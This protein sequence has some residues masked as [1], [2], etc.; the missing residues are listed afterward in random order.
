MTAPAPVPSPVAARRRPACAAWS[1]HAA[2]LA[3]PVAAGIERLEESPSTQVLVRDGVVVRLLPGLYLPPDLLG[4][5][6]GRALALGAATGDL[7][8]EDHV[9]A[10]ASAA[11]VLLGGAP[12][13]PAEMLSRAHRGPVAGVLVRSGRI[14]PEEVE[15]LGGAPVTTPLRTAVDLLVIDPSP[16]RTRLVGRLLHEG[17]LDGEEVTGRLAGMRSHPGARGARDRLVAARE[18]VERELRP[19]DP[20][21]QR[22]ARCTPRAR[23]LAARRSEAA[24]LRPP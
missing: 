24:G 18:S 23:I 13:D 9:I 1:Q 21:I 5:A 12:P 14:G 2:E 7:L 22:A 4:S 3:E 19:A 10:G 20:V 8:R 6:L 16:G 15:T 17:H 11:W